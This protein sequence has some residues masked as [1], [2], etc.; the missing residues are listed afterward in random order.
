MQKPITILFLFILTFLIGINAFAQKIKVSTTS[1]E[2]IE[3]KLVIKYDITGTRESQ[4]FNVSLDITSATGQRIRANNVTGDLGNNISGGPDKQIIWDYTAD[5]LIMN[6]NLN[7]EVIAILATK[8]VNVGKSLVFSAVCP[9]LGLSKMENKKSFLL[10]GLAA[11]GC[12]GSSILLNMKGNNSYDA[13]VS[14]TIDA[15]NDEL[16]NKSQNQIQLSKTLAYSAL[17][18]W[19]TSLIWTLLKGH[20]KNKTELAGIDKNRFLFYSLYDPVTNTKGFSIRYRF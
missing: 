16:F 9:G 19:G 20:D 7:I 18:I 14:N 11:Y 13:Y 17:G 4:L 15:Q 5:N 3:N 12:L 1:I 10:L 8:S 2:N 6:G